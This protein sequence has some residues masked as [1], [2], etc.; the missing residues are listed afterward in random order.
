LVEDPK[1][2]LAL[3]AT[4]QSFYQHLLSE[5]LGGELPAPAELAPEVISQPRNVRATLEQMHRWIQLLDMAITPAMLRL[6]VQSDLDPE[7]AEALLRYFA[8][9][10]DDSGSNRDKT[11]LVATFLFRHPRVAGQWQQ[12]GYGLDGSIPLS[13]FEIALLE[14]LSESEI[15]VL[16]DEDVQLLR[17]FDPL[18]E[19]ANRFQDF[20][21]LMDSG[22]IQRV[23]QL[24]AS[25]GES[26]YHP[27]VLATLAPYNAAFGDRF[28]MLFSAATEEIKEFAKRLEG[29]GGSILSTVD[30]V[31]V[32]VDHVAALNQEALLQVDYSAAL[33]KFRRVSRLKRE[34]ERRPPIRRPKLDSTATAHTG[35]SLGAAAA[36]AKEAAPPNPYIPAAVT[37]QALSV[38]EA[39][40]R[41]VEESIRVF[42]RVADPKFRQIVPMRYF[43][44]ILSPAEVEAFTADYLEQTG[45]RA[46]AA[47]M[48][49]RVV[50]VTARLTTEL[51]ELK[52]SQNSPSLWRLHADASAVLI[53]MAERLAD[54]VARLASFIGQ[55]PQGTPIGESLDSS[56][57]TLRER[58]LE[59]TRLIVA[60]RE[61]ASH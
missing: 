56:L 17:E 60:A 53:D 4:V 13:P 11:D 33:E 29:L 1:W 26:V 58:A 14:I 38:E 42:V 27:G 15:P 47:R 40:V 44:L 46:D 18:L 32:T 6:G 5:Q 7:V 2:E 24:K 21:A 22:I 49:I 48:R 10:R 39:R 34:L 61:F 31:E 20:S 51:E 35:R 28:H 25:L 55:P 37:P 59:A 45:P 41:R 3:L 8:R 9:N 43:N 50:A 16:S 23:R 54:A 52:R 12:R 57:E 30:G 36:L 19:Q